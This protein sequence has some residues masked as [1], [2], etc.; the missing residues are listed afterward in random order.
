MERN[1]ISRC[2]RERKL[3]REVLAGITMCPKGKSPVLA[4]PKKNYQEGLGL[5]VLADF[6]GITFTP[7]PYSI[8]E[9]ISN[10]FGVKIEWK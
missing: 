9:A 3:I 8:A 7:D 4:R 6:E 5:I 1:E 2:R 10:Y